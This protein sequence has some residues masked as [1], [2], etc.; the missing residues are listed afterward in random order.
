MSLPLAFGTTVE[1]I[2][3]QVP[4]LY[5]PQEALQKAAALGWPEKG[6]RVGVAWTGNPSH[7]KNRFRSVPLELLAKL[8]DL[9]G[10]HFYSLQLGEAAAELAAL[11]TGVADLSAATG[12]MADT[13]AQ[14]ARMDLIISIDTSMAHLAGALGRPLWVLLCHTPDWRW[15][16]ER[17][18]CP[19]YPTARLF[20]Q[21]QPGDWEAVIERVRGELAA[22]AQQKGWK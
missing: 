3:A 15:L 22:L 10:V 11:K 2:P 19:W 14:M 20:R 1:T 18:D 21:S 4:Y 5:A 9:E 13:A 12:D 7:P 6:L 17:E 16:L 8:F